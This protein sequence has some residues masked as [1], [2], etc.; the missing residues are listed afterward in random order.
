MMGEQAQ[1]A[2]H[3]MHRTTLSELVAEPER[4]ADAA[5]SGPMRIERPGAPDLVLLS[6]E[7]FERLRDRGPR[8]Q[9]LYASELSE[10][11]I[12]MMLAQEI[13]EETRQFDH[14]GG[15]VEPR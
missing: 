5:T 4:V 9:A 12:E 10:R 3:P 2:D 15:F 14:E 1:E 7:A 8:V 11:E 6:A 13:P